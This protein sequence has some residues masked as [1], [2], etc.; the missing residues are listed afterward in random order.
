MPQLRTP[1]PAHLAVGNDP[2]VDDSAHGKADSIERIMIR[3]ELYIWPRSSGSPGSIIPSPWRSSQPELSA[4]PR[5]RRSLGPREAPAAAETAGHP[6]PMRRFP[7]RTSSPACRMFC[8]PSREA[9]YDDPVAD[10]LAV[11]LHDDGIEP[12][13]HGGAGEYAECLSRTNRRSGVGVACRDPAANRELPR[14]GFDEIG[15]S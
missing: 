10:A 11:F 12:I 9:R 2:K 14:P 15:E 4:A 5:L 3:L 8:S 7:A 1:R 6:A 13:R